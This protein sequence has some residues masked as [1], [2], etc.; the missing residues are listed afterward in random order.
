MIHKDENKNGTFVFPLL[1]HERTEVAGRGRSTGSKLMDAPHKN[2]DTP[3][4]TT[5]LP[6]S[7]V[8]RSIGLIA[9]GL[10]RFRVMSEHEHPL[11]WERDYRS[12]P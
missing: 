2:D 7:S 5:S 8:Q 6:D 11:E 12:H 4:S 1:L 9:L 10:G 3:Q